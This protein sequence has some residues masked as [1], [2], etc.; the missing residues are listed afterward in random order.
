MHRQDKDLI[1]TIKREAYHDRKSDVRASFYVFIT[2][3]QEPFT[4]DPVP[5]KKSYF[6]APNV[7]QQG[8]YL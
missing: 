8:Y 6:F 1:G 2:L 7:A 5:V 4:R 3:Q